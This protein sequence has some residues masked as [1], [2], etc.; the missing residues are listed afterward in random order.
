[1]CFPSPADRGESLSYIEMRDA[2]VRRR[3][4]RVAWPVDMPMPSQEPRLGV[5]LASARP[6]AEA[7]EE[8]IMLKAFDP[9]PTRLSST[10]PQGADTLLWTVADNSYMEHLV[11]AQ[12]YCAANRCHKSHILWPCGPNKRALR[13]LVLAVVRRARTASPCLASDVIQLSRWS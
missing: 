10:P 11:G 4:C 9:D 6:G 2:G 5:T 7:T 12:G 1:M 8:T 3:V 13:G